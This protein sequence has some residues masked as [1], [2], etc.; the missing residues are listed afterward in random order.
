MLQHAARAKPFAS[1]SNLQT[2][3]QQPTPNVVT[4]ERA[5]VGQHEFGSG[6]CGIMAGD[7]CRRHCRDDSSQGPRACRHQRACPVSV[8]NHAANWQRCASV[9][10]QAAMAAA[11]C[12]AAIQQHRGDRLPSARCFIR[13]LDFHIGALAPCRRS[14]CHINAQAEYINEYLTRFFWITA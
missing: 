5:D 1:S 7:C 12:K 9:C 11:V 8:G 4:T 6:S 3:T 2:G 10:L 13:R 14:A